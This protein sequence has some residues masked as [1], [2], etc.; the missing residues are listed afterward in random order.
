[1]PRDDWVHLLALAAP[2]VACIWFSL[3]LDNT[4]RCN[5]C[6]NEPT[7]GLGPKRTLPVVPC[8]TLPIL[9]AVKPWSQICHQRRLLHPIGTAP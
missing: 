5:E 6:P 3:Q 4:T 2:G 8:A 9:R 1:M 7:A